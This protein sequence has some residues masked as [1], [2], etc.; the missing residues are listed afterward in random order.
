M[1]YIDLDDTDGFELIDDFNETIE[2]VN[3]TETGI[4]ETEIKIEDK[5]KIENII[6]TDNIIDEK[7]IED[8]NKIDLNE[9]LNK[10]YSK[11]LIQLD[12]IKKYINKKKYMKQF[13]KKINELNN[14]INE[15][16]YMH[17]NQINNFTDNYDIKIKD[18][19]NFLKNNINIVKFYI[20]NILT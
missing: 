1:D 12:N 14:D 6:K 11:L 17:K 13:I 16:Y 9:Y 7:I 10:K 3:L 5:I 8:K 20:Y 4:I 15:F 18:D 19:Y 2:I